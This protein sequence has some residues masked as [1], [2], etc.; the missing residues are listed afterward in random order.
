V[1]IRCEALEN[2][3]CDPAIAVFEQA[4]RE[5]GLPTV[6]RTDNG[7]GAALAARALRPLAEAA[8]L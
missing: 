8:P 6:I 5:Y 3:K 1:I 4:F 2:A 7:A